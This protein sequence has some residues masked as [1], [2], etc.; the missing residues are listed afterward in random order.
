[1]PLVHDPS[2]QD[3]LKKELS[4]KLGMLEREQ[5]ERLAEQRAERLSLPY[6]SLVT[7]PMDPDILEVVPKADAQAAGAVLF[8]RQGKDI[9]LGAVNPAL[10]EVKAVVDK[11]QERFRSEPQVYVISARSLA[12]SLSRYRRE[13]EAEVVPEQELR[14]QEQGGE[15][16][17]TIRKIE[18]LK[19]HIVSLP[20]TEVLNAIVA[21]AV[22]ARASDIHIEPE[23]KQ[24]RLRYRIDGVLQDIAEFAREGWAL[25]L[26]R[27]KVLAKLKLN[28]HDT[29]QD[30]SFVLRLR[31]DTPASAGQAYDIRISTLPGAWGENIVMRILSRTSQLVKVTE[32]GMKER[33]YKVV[34]RE[35]KRPNGMIL[36]TGPTGSGKTT[37]LASFV[38]EI[39]SP[40]VKII[41]LEDPIEYRLAGVEQ[42][43][44]DAEAGYTF[45]KGLRSILRQ[46]PDVIL[47]GEMRDIETAE[48][49]V[50]AALTG[51]LVFSTLHT[52]D[53]PGA[54]PR[55]LSMGVKPF[56][57]APALNL[58][59]AQRLV[60]VVCEH[61]AEK[62]QPDEELRERIAN[63]MAGVRRDVFDP[64]VLQKPKLTFVRAKGCAQCG[65]MGYRGRIGLF[66]I[67]SVEGKMEQLVLHGADGSQIL[68]EALA[69]GMTTILQD[70]YMKVI[71][72]VTTVEEVERISEA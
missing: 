8:Y 64:K 69:Q 71:D 47:V 65:Q 18:E 17:K 3:E 54:V 2:Q 37:T 28:V 48:T 23:E 30:G 38:N 70:G 60:R 67:F 15:K 58:V 63:T 56:V 59:I 1:M 7:F 72:N 61:C 27:V 14:I 34:Q 10:P 40:D 46:D 6:I 26:S 5:E 9:R 62:Y 66:E 39:N 49:A 11:L 32:L 13:R 57:L 24:A 33:D 29:P 52:N 31:K 21:E 51:H 22:E 42:T 68:Q 55:L 53:A 50:N 36:V 25:L 35:L 44:V 20:P 4:A 16:R 41:T 43:E 12:A 45:A 19:Q